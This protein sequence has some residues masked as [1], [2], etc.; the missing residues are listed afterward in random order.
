MRVAALRCLGLLAAAPVAAQLPAAPHL[1]LN[2][3]Y[4][5]VD[6][7]TYHDITASNFLSGQFA[8]FETR[9]TESGGIKWT[10]TYLYGRRTY[11]EIFGPRGLPGAQVGDVGIVLGTE[12]A[13]ELDSLRA[14]FAAEQY[15]VDTLTRMHPDSGA[16][17][18]WFM[19][20]R[21]GGA[22]RTSD[23]VSLSIMEYSAAMAGRAAVHDSLPLTD[24]SRYRF[25]EGQF[26]DSRLLGDLTGATLALPAADLEKMQRT[27]RA[28]GVTVEAEG[29]GAVIRLDAFTLHLTTAWERPGVRRLEFA[30]LREAVA[31]PTYRFGPRT[32]L[33]FGPGAFAAWEFAIL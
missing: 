27:L 21:A 17:Y 32:R 24:R 10:G 25:R 1:Y 6:S 12:R 11:L 4:L 8:G 33:R 15:P 13:G 31:N 22:D 16:P 29:Q 30:L 2:H 19:A 23:R 14:R 18:P 5:V 28:A 26:D 9:T 3:L 7:A 20:L